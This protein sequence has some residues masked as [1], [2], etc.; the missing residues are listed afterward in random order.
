MPASFQI[1]LPPAEAS[2]LALRVAE[3]YRTDIIDHTSRM[4]KCRRYYQAF[5]RRVDPPAPGDEQKSNFRVPL[6]Q[7]QVF[8]EWAE[9]MSALF[10]DDAQIVGKPVGPDDQTQSAK[11]STYMT[12][13]MFTS[14]KITS[15]LAMFIFRKILFGKSF[16][17][18]PWVVKK[19]DA[20][21]GGQVK[22]QVYYEGPDFV[23][24]WPDDLIC[25]SEDVQTIQEFSHVIRRYRATPDQLL[26][27]DGT[28]YQ[29]IRQ[30]F[31]KIVG[32]GQRQQREVI[33]EEVKTE[34]D[35]DD[36]V[37]YTHAQSAGD[38]LVV[39]EWHGRW[40]PLL[41]GKK[42]GDLY[43]FKARSMYEQDL[44]V[45]T[46]P[47]LGDMLIG[48][49]DLLA[50]YPKMQNRRP[51]SEASSYK[52][53][54]YWP[55]GL[56]EMLDDIE[57]E[58]SSNHNLFTD[59]QQLSVWPLIFYSPSSGWDPKATKYGPGMAIPTEQPDKVH[60]VNVRP[61]LQGCVLKE[62]G[63]LAYAERVTG[64]SDSSLGRSSDRPNAPRTATG[65]LAL[66]QQGNIRADL[67]MRFL[68]EDV[69]AIARD[70]WELDQQFCDEKVF[71]RVTGEDADGLFD[72]IRGGAYMTPDEFGSQYDFDIEFA[73]NVWSRET[74]KQ[75]ALELYQLDLGN[76]LIVQ[77]PTA[78]WLI[79]NRMHKAMGDADFASIVP[80]PP[81]ADMPKNPTKEW[82]MMLQGQELHPN[83]QDND[84]F[85]LQDHQR[86]LI[87]YVQSKGKSA[88][89]DEGAV[90]MM[91]D[92]IQEHKHQRAS[93]MMQQMMMQQLIRS[94]TPQQQQG[95]GFS[96]QPGGSGADIAALIGQMGGGQQQPVQGAPPDRGMQQ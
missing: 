53:G 7:W 49:Q 21:E 56:G 40:R 20:L 23:P 54:T 65:Q 26:R 14:M 32:A 37:L 90:K 44:V 31:D 4:E 15:N 87:D 93:K 68:R 59:A 12:W 25:P 41:K 34:N 74:E 83:V 11:V 79:T 81:E 47:E 55:P 69:A 58:V 38:S 75:K 36:G 8:I 10:G 89:Y 91:I 50:L 77:N 71:F 85:H 39:H 96:G 43:D 28:L 48:C 64:N 17:Y 70:I 24:L 6:T 67:D 80:Q 76:P 2:R 30:N 63:T 94:V 22:D 3:D 86:R 92:H 42:D 78:L 18:R 51:F 16:A 88:N 73:T 5:R 27:G 1:K 33:G 82:S 62:Q 9:Q 61:D 66:I 35:L 95:G 19:F 46:L 52:I 57:E 84:D 13:R 72:T 29:G 60:V 45:R